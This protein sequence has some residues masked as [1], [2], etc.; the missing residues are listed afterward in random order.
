MTNF[1]KYREQLLNFI[2]TNGVTPAREDGEFARCGDTSCT[3]CD[4][5]DKNCTAKLI[6]WLYEDDDADC[7]PDASKPKG[8]CEGCHYEGN[9]ILNMP[10]CHC[11]RAIMD[12][13]EPKKKPE[14]KTKTRQDEFLGMF[15][16]AKGIKI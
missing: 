5:R 9:N 14:K 11:E 4:F 6:K 3:E 13:F 10:C 1:E 2:S 12:C 7:S 15:P 16:N 8:G